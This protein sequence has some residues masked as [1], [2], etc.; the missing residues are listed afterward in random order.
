MLELFTLYPNVSPGIT[1]YDPNIGVS[2]YYSLIWTERY[3][4]PGEF[5]MVLP[6]SKTT[7]SVLYRGA[8][9]SHTQT[10]EVMRVETH[11]ISLDEELGPVVTITGRSFDSFL[12]YRVAMPSIEGT[13]DRSNDNENDW[14]VI[15][16]VLHED[17]HY[18]LAYSVEQAKY[19]ID[20]IIVAG[21]LSPGD[22]IPGVITEYEVRNVDE[23]HVRTV[24]RGK[25]YDAVMELISP[26]DYG[27]K[28]KRNQG[29][30]TISYVI[31]DGQVLIETVSFSVGAGDLIEPDY[32]WS[33]VQPNYLIMVGKYD[34]IYTG[35]DPSQV[36]PGNHAPLPPV[37][38]GP[39]GL[40]RKT[41]LVVDTDI[42]QA[43]NADAV[44]ELQ[45]SAQAIL[46]QESD[47]VLIQGKVDKDSTQ[48][49]KENYNIG[50]IVLVEGEYDAVAIMR[51]SE[52]I[53]TSDSTGI[54]GYPA[55]SAL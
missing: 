6:V 25:L 52:H 38:P 24:T 45:Y 42:V 32:F 15:V 49:Y 23:P 7:L 31:H 41:G 51:V 43:N 55:L 16:P 17:S 13:A 22:I 48:V 12:E 37:G 53:L 19:I 21:R 36:I 30:G 27:L 46:A 5:K 9:I 26:L 40:D 2:D 47:V 18:G 4:T 10:E 50:D 3:N 20:Q 14:D 33:D 39:I 28:T 8:L 34:A 54:Y 29:E 35:K 44:R 11:E 1:L